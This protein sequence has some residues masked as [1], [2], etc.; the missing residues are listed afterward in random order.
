MSREDIA[1]YLGLALDTVSRGFSRLQEDG[2]I[3]VFGRRVEIV[4]LPELNRL[5][6]GNDAA[7]PRARSAKPGRA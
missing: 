6:H 2:V 3:S 5:A 4:D 7:E 1:S